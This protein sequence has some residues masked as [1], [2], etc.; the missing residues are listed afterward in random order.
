MKELKF[1]TNINCGGCLASVTPIL[2]AKD[3]IANWE[4]DLQ[5]DDR[6]LSVNTDSLSEEE[7][8]AAVAEAGFQAIVKQ[9]AS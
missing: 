5:D 4:V 2:D 8:Q 6:T 7:V 3:G 9:P 1:K